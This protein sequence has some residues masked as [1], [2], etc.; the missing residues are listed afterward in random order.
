MKS[1]SDA[2]RDG[3]TADGGTPSSNNEGERSASSSG[4]RNEDT[5]GQPLEFAASHDAAGADE[6]PD[7]N[8]D[9]DPDAKRRRGWRIG[10]SGPTPLDGT[11]APE[12]EL[13]AAVPGSEPPGGEEDNRPLG[14]LPPGLAGYRLKRAPMKSPPTPISRAELAETVVAKPIPIQKMPARRR[15]APEEAAVPAQ[16]KA[17]PPPHGMAAT[18]PP[19]KMPPVAKAAA[20]AAASTASTAPPAPMRNPTTTAVPPQPKS[21]SYKAPPGP[22][23][24]KQPPAAVGMPPSPGALA[25]GVRGVKAPPGPWPNGEGS[26]LSSTSTLPMPSPPG[27]SHAEATPAGREGREGR[28]GDEA[29]TKSRAEAKEMFQKKSGP[30]PPAP[31]ALNPA[32]G[33]IEVVDV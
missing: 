25:K 1:G 5:E 10:R 33:E 14:P 22:L 24:Y 3:E 30:V 32:D 20:A 21:S 16:P 31:K 9:G 28:E 23:V 18:G 26:A 27:L 8:A 19:R 4:P 17:K 15:I 29:R 2:S 12:A 7:A 6:T 13:G 11:E